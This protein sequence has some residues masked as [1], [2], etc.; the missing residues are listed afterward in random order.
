MDIF[1]ILGR[2]F[3]ES[4]LLSLSDHYSGQCVGKCLLEVRLW[5]I[6]NKSLFITSTKVVK[7]HCKAWAMY[8]LLHPNLEDVT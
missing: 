7:S 1:V 3:R 6:T 4:G 2:D 8:L 5:I